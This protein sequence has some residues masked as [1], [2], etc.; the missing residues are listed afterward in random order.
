MNFAVGG[1]LQV[2]LAG[3]DDKVFSATT[4]LSV[5]KIKKLRLESMVMS[6]VGRL[7]GRCETHE[8]SGCCSSVFPG[9]G[10]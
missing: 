4:P 7:D 10:S 8:W 1:G 5:S 9:G 6:E 2:G 3:S